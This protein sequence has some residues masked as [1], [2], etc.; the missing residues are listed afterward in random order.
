MVEKLLEQLKNQDPSERRSALESLYDFSSDERVLK[1]A[2]NLITDDD[3]GVREAASRLLVLCSNEQAAVLVA[4]HI[5]SGNIAVRNLA[6]DS[7]VRMKAAAIPAL[8]PYVDSSDKDLRKFAIDVLA[9]LPPS[10]TSVEKIAGHLEDSDQNVVGAC[11]DALGALHS[12]KYIDAL[13]EIYGKNESLRPNVVNALAVFS[14]RVALEFLEKALDDA[15]PVVQLAAAEAL[16]S[17]KDRGLLE[18]L[19]RKMNSVSDLAKPVVLHSVIQLLESINCPVALPSDLR[20]TLLGMLDDADA[21]Y[22]RAAVRGLKYFDDKETIESLVH[23]L[24][25]FEIVDN[26]ICTALKGRVED[27]LKFICSADVPEDKYAPVLKLVL[28]LLYDS[29]STDPA[30]THSTIFSDAAEFIDGIFAK[31]NVDSKMAVLSTFT[32]LGPSSSTGIVRK[33]LEDEESSVKTY[34]LDLAARIGPHFFVEQ[35]QRL[36]TDYDEDIRFAAASMLGVSDTPEE[37]RKE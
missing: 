30:F 9:Q 14:E 25:R 36:T 15:D 13:M 10:D 7:L 4:V 18:V 3:R 27:T 33:A 24:G 28:S 37:D 31:L 29:G 26:A 17:R 35:L 16:A 20:N 11:I 32:H 23:H 21:S 12:E 5:S 1:A 22:V 6:G 34:A 8:I 19:I 2:A